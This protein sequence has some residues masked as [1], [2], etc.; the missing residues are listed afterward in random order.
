MTTGV[1]V[2]RGTPAGTSNRPPF[3]R[4]RVTTYEHRYTSAGPRGNLLSGVM[5]EYGA[6]PVGAPRRWRDDHGDFVPIRFGPFKAHLAFGPAE[7]EEV[8]VDRAAD[9]RKSFG[10]RMLIPLL[11]RG[12]LTAEG[13]DWLRH[14]RLAAPA[15]HRER[16][17]GYGRTMARYAEDSVESWSEGQ[18]V[19]VHDEMT[20][21]TLRIVARTLFDTDVTARIEEVAR[22]GT[23]IQ[24]FYYLRFASLR[25]LIPTWLPT[26]G[27]RRLA[28]ARRRLDGVVYRI[29]RE[30]QPGEDRGDLLSML[31]L[32]RDDHGNGMSERQVRDEVM[33]LLL[34][35]HETTALALSWAFLLLDRNPEA[36]DRLEAELSAVLDGRFALPTDVPSLPFTQAVV[37]ETLRLYPPAYVTG[38]E[39]I[40]DTTVGGLE[41]PRGHIVLIS[42]YTTHRDPRFYP[43]PDAFRPERWLDGLEKRL[44]RGAF[45]P[46]GLGSRKCI[47]SSFAMMEAVVLLATIARRWRFELAP[48]EVGTHPSITLRPAAALPGHMRRV[49]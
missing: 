4:Q 24:D 12:L 45:I 7:I 44:P 40:R 15:F 48:G 17:E 32:S 27:N 46:F 38:R 43:E 22:I 49:A 34:A 28:A 30:R 25:F 19:D 21:L 33:T 31:L 6:E 10:T 16:V 26:P 11:G 39:A 1:P 13:D 37:N 42:M 14:R 5:G 8:L 47:G 29:I 2:D 9:F 20:A 3:D 36:R 23:W 18:A 35:G 41:I